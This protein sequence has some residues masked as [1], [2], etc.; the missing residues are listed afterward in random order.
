MAAPSVEQQPVS[1]AMPPALVRACVVLA[2]LNAALFIAACLSHGWI[3]DEKGL[4]IPVDFVGIWA[5]G[6]LVLSGEAAQA[7]VWDV[8]KQIQVAVLGQDFDG[9]YGWHYP[10]PFLIVAAVLAQFP[11]AA[12]FV[13]W[14]AAS[15]AP[16]MIAVRALVGRP[17]GWLVACACPVILPNLFVG[18]NGFLTASL[19]G[20]GLYFLPMRPVLAGICIGLLSYKPQ[21]GILFP[22]LLLVAGQ[23][24]AITAAAATTLAMVAVTWL[25]FGAETWLAFAHWLP[26]T[27]HRFLSVGGDIFGKM[28]SLFSAVRYFGGSEQLAWVCQVVLSAIVVVALIWL[29]RSRAR[30]ALKAA[31]LATGTL[32]V[33]PYLF[34]YD[35]AVLAVPVALLLRLGLSRGFLAHELPALALAAALL[36]IYPAVMAPTGLL[37]SLLVAALIA[38]RCVALGPM[39]VPHRAQSLSFPQA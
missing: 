12:A 18:H 13:G 16:Y 1:A 36:V 3:R 20:G 31:G 2:A 38:R 22:L 37:A 28:Q 30:Y 9:I 25:A 11:Y 5:A 26:M 19:I 14:C 27:S 21:F 24:K 7:Y 10:P 23:W 6:K 4:G 33:T 15:L 32:L 8:H 34:L 17:V 35:M 29:W 39:T